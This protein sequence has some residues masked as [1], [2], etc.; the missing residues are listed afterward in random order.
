LRKFSPCGK[1]LI[2]FSSDQSSLEIYEFKGASAAGDLIGENWTDEVVP[3]VNRDKAYEIRSKIFDKLFKLKHVVNMD[4]S[5]KQLNRECSLFCNDGKHVI[6]G[7]AIL[8]SDDQRPHFYELY[9]NNEFISTTANCP[10]EDYT[11]YI[12]DLIEGRITDSIEFK[13]DKIILSHNQG[14]YL[15]NDTLAVLSIQHQTIHVYHILEGSFMHV[16]QIGRFCCDEEQFLYSS[17]S[18]NISRAFREPTINSLKHRIL[19]HLFNQAKARYIEGDR[20]ALRKFY[21]NFD[22][23]LGLRMWKMQLLDEDHLLIKYSDEAVV[24]LKV[25][26]PNSHASFFVI[27]N[28]WEKK[29]L[30]V[31]SNISDE[32]LYLFENFTDNFRNSKLSFN[33]QWTCSP[34]NN[35]YANLLH[36]RFKQTIISAKGGG[37]IEATKRIN[38][39]LPISA[40][41][42]SSSPYLDLSLFSYDDKWVSIMERPKAASEFPIRFFARDSGLLRFRIHAVQ[43][44]GLPGRR[45][46]AFCFHP[47]QPFAISVQRINTDYIVNFHLWNSNV[48]VK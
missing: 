18:G 14:L 16:R 22:Q 48:K 44:Q 3:N 31:H 5:E 25:H 42:Y 7:A 12:I 19:V 28:I 27:Y 9:T 4:G 15:Y 10:L 6:V 33:S 39:Q 1:F 24:T 29:I 36:Q 11:L 45:L 32:L 46:V 41:S 34:S 35:I 40:Q 38:A 23:F 20:V 43:K 37:N 21:Q 17:T 47:S 8:I 30:A 26:E 2:A 13:N